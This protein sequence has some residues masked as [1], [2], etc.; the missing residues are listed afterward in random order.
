MSRYAIDGETMTGIADAVR[1]MRHEKK[2]MTPAQIEAKIRAS[3]LGVPIVVSTHVN[4]DTGEW[5]R[6]Q[7][8]PDLNALAAT[9]ADDEDCVYLTYDLSKT[10]GYGWIG[11]RCT[12]TTSDAKYTVERGHVAG[13]AF[14]ADEATEVTNDGYF[15]AAL[16]VANGNIQL[17]RVRSDGKI[18]TFGFTPNTGTTAQNYQNNH[19]PCVEMAGKLP[20]LTSLA[21]NI[22]T[23]YSYRCMGT[24]WL[25][26]MAVVAGT[27]GKV[28]TL[29]SCFNACYSLQSLDLSG[30]NTS[31]WA[32]TDTRS[33]FA[34]CNNLATLKVPASLG[35]VP[36]QATNVA[37]HRPNTP[38]IQHFNGVE[39]YVNHT[40]AAA[41]KLTPDSLRA[42]LQ[43]LP[44]VSAARTI[45]LSQANRL[46]LTAE[47]IAVATQK[48]WTVA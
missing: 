26:R 34:A 20:Y 23:N 24:V 10:P 21:S 29:A 6:P 30:W 3:R 41:L 22:S 48:G 13:G 39:I 1:G 40:Y 4:P 19:Q 16:D 18:T 32:V 35:V 8:W 28:T 38:N 2:L 47:E 9:V 33:M 37:E 25:E 44:T 17:W 27:R 15:R 11:L 46:K 31:G 42:I 36:T 5:E 12:N 43:R 45:T 7:D 14:V